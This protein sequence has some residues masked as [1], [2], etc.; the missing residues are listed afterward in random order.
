[1]SEKIIPR[2]RRQRDKRLEAPPRMCLTKRDK[3]II[4]AVCQFRVLRQSQ[5][6]ALFFGD[7][8]PA[9]QRRLVNLYDYGYL[10]RY[11][12][13][14]RGGLMSSPILYGLAKSGLE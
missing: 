12:L 13:P 3:E 10:E 5:V 11:F 9:A 2:R 7:K 1:M 6:E 4:Q 14:T 8:K